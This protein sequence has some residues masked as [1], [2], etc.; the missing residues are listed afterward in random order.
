MSPDVVAR[1][2]VVSGRR[3]DLT[4]HVSAP[5]S[6][7]ENV[8]GAVVGVGRVVVVAVDPVVVGAAVSAIVLA[9]VGDGVVVTATDVLTVTDGPTVADGT[10]SSAPPLATQ[11]T[12]PATRMTIAIATNTTSVR[13]TAGSGR[14][15]GAPGVHPCPG[16]VS[17]SPA[18]PCSGRSTPPGVVSSITASFDC[19]R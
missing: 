11:T 10:S 17:A 19:L 4:V 12:R 2:S 6:G 15:G 5:G 3:S 9:V 16:L 14:D 1:S 7:S 13:P 8:G 18:L